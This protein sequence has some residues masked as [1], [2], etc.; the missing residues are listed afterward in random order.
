MAPAHP[1]WG[2]ATPAHPSMTPSHPGSQTPSRGAGG[3]TPLRESAW[4]PLAGAATPVH[5]GAS[6]APRTPAEDPFASSHGSSSYDRPTPG[7]P[8]YGDSYAAVSTPG[9]AY[10][11]YTMADTPN[12]PGVHAYTPAMTP[13]VG[14]A[15]TPG[16]PGFGALRTPYD[17]AATPGG[18]GDGATPF[19]P[20]MPVSTPGGMVGTPSHT[21]FTPGTAMAGTPATPGM[22]PM[23]PGL[24]GGGVAVAMDHAMLQDLLVL[25]GSSDEPAEGRA[26]G[27]VRSVDPDSGECVLRLGTLDDDGMF[28]LDGSGAE[29]HCHAGD[30]TLVVPQKKNAVKIV[31]GEHRGQTG[32][33][34]GVDAAD[35][36]VKLEPSGDVKILELSS[37]GRLVN[38]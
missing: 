21:P 13:D 14:A 23:S 11:P 38:I 8:G 4:N 27:V 17:S 33:L 19:T 20:G 31:L 9:A 10:T 16:T 22:E 26:V 36:I 25:R 5:P 1:S 29:A 32:S 2:G 12:T 28:D 7:T 24:G 6:G 35:G 30:L 15:A 34:I 3:R 37:L 18:A